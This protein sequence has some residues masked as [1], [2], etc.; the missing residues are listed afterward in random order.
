MRTSLLRADSLSTLKNK[1]Y[2]DNKG[3]KRTDKHPDG[4]IER[5]D[6]IRV[7]SADWEILQFFGFHIFA[8]RFRSDMTTAGAGRAQHDT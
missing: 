7:L 8:E 6:K 4:H 3:G 5:N 2:R 1:P